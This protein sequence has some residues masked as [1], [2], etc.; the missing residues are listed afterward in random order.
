MR[1]LTTAM[2]RMQADEIVSRLGVDGIHALVQGSWQERGQFAGDTHDI[3]VEEGDLA[4]ARDAIAGGEPID[5]AELTRLSE[6][7]YREAM[8][9]EDPP[10]ER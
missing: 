5:E 2:S 7:S 1:L 6:Q 8:D 10:H 3:Y 4:R 9:G